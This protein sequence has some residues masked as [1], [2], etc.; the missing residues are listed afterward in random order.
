MRL[1]KSSPS[2]LQSCL[3][4]T[5]VR[6]LVPK[7]LLLQG[8]LLESVGVT[9]P[10]AGLPAASKAALSR[11]KGL[12]I[13]TELT[14]ISMFPFCDWPSFSAATALIPSGLA[15][16]RLVPFTGLL[17]PRVPCCTPQHVHE[18]VEGRN[19]ESVWCV[20]K[21]AVNAHREIQ[22]MQKRQAVS[23]LPGFLSSEAP[24]EGIPMSFKAGMFPGK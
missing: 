19:Q 8:A 13:I 23:F 16:Y 3:D 20:L 1:H 11:L 15:F 22:E 4:F 17:V 2:L 24:A 5:Q 6:D 14:D 12:W 10:A 9:P 7:E 18:R 21:L